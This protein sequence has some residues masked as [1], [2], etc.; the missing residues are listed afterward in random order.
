ML[1]RNFKETHFPF[2]T[3]KFKMSVENLTKMFDLKSKFYNVGAELHVTRDPD[4]S[5]QND[6]K[7]MQGNR[8]RLLRGLV[9]IVPNP[10]TFLNGTISNRSQYF[11]PGL[12]T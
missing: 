1:L 3:F 5:E 8:D 12:A 7:K 11:T 2:H 4:S 6:P 9:L 10:I